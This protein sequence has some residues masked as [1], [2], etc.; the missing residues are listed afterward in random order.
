MSEQSP[1][2]HV[3]HD[4]S[5]LLEPQIDRMAALLDR[6]PYRVVAM[7]MAM[8]IVMTMSMT[9]I[10]ILAGDLWTSYTD[11]SLCFLSR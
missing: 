5:L 6:L 11:R 4:L 2:F 1:K 8:M 3:L 10:C 7:M 9:L